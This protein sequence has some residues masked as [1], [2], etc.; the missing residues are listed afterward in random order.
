MREKKLADALYKK[1]REKKYYR[2]ISI[3]VFSSIESNNY[4]IAEK[5]I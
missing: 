4:L 3:E 2:K 1:K 5:S